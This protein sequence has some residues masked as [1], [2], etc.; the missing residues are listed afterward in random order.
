MKQILRLLFLALVVLALVGTSASAS[1]GGTRGV[2]KAATDGFYAYIDI[3]TILMWVAN[4]GDGSFDPNTGIA[5]FYWPRGTS[6]TAVYEDGLI[7]G[8][9]VNGALHV[10]GS[11]YSHGLQAGPIIN[12][13]AANR[14]D[15]KYRVYKIRKDYNDFKATNPALYDQL[16][17][18]YDEW[19]TDDGAPYVLDAQGNKVPQFIGDEVLWYVANDLDPSKVQKLMGSSPIGLEIQ[20][21]VWGYNQVG[22]LGDMVFKK[23]RVINKGQ[24]RV[25]SMY[26]GSWAD[27]D[28]GQASD[29]FSGCDT[30]LSL[31]YTYNDHGTDAVYN[32]A[33]VANGFDF[34]QGPIVR[35]PGDTANFNFEKRAGYR[36]LKMTAYVFYI[37]GS[38][39][40]SD[41]ELGGNPLG[42]IQMYRYLNGRIGNTGDPFIDPT[43]GKAT[44]F[45]LAGDPVTNKGWVDGTPAAS[46]DR[47]QLMSSGPFVMMPGDTQEIV[48]AI[49]M[50]QGSDRSS[51]ITALKNNAGVAQA[52]YNINFQLPGPPPVPVVKVA[53]LDKEVILDWGDAAGSKATEEYVASLIGTYYTFEGYDVYQL[54]S[55]S[56]SRDRWKRLAVYDV[57]DGVKV[58]KFPTFD[59]VS[60]EFIDLPQQYGTDSGVKRE[61]TATKDYINDRPLVNGTKYYFVVSAYSYNPHAPFGSNNLENSPPVITVVPHSPNPGT[62]YH[63]VNGDTLA[64]THAAG[65]SDG[66]VLP[67]V[68]DPTKLTGHQYK[69]TFDTVSVFNTVD[70]VWEVKTRW[71]LTEWWKVT[72]VTTG[73]VKDTSQVKYTSFAFSGINNGPAGTEGYYPTIDGINLVI[74]GPLPGVRRDS[75]NPMGWSFNPSANRFF[76]AQTAWEL[77]LEAFGDYFGRPNSLGWPNINNWF[78]V[79]N[80][81][82]TADKLHKV[83]IRFLG[84]NS[85]K[86]HRFLRLATKAAA[87]PSYVPFI[88]N[89]VGGYAYQDFVTVPFTAWDVDY[90]HGTPSGGR[91]LNIG[92]LENNQAPPL[93]KVDGQWFPQ[94]TSTGG[95]EILFVWSSTYTGSPDPRYTDVLSDLVDCYYL[96]WPAYRNSDVMKEGTFTITPNYPITIADQYTYASTVPTVGDVALSKSE[97]ERINVWPNPYFG[98]NAQELNKYQRF[99]TFNHLP[100]RATIRVFSLSG[101]PVAT[102]EKNDQTQFATW[103][104]LNFNNIPV[105]SGMYIIYIDMPD[106]GKTKILKLG[107][108]MEAQYLDRI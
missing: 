20:C 92:F 28:L 11:T 21:T 37:N 66:I 32:T 14:D 23:Y 25:D 72:D 65:T 97:I 89:K 87:D 55:R 19:P 63:N 41:P 79:P 6:K 94:N 82:V 18:D 58:I 106:L 62:T 56:A 105:A 90:A 38:P 54:P 107:I 33:A 48:I 108:I 16:K 68:V 36:N 85:Q 29:D 30:S 96:L 4:D 75:Q 104:L 91:Q 24:N 93:G 26:L 7:W 34:F 49:I 46:G 103:N 61:F 64:V 15:P 8:G 52:A 27:V 84:S 22:A 10:G 69:V 59:P 3:N 86:A 31:G 95:R 57:I 83:E 12:G 51:S 67:F 42:S 81:G 60:G 47:R 99:V 73:Q 39:V 2:K 13:A 77:G 88:I 44:V 71:T 101:V 9:Y 70:S 1:G 50:A 53:E 17:K 45:C 35:S 98:F 40:Y 80:D 74:S 76:A 102:V 5:G 43:T 100:Q 78:G